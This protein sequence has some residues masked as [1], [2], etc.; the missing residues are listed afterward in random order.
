MVSSDKSSDFAINEEWFQKVFE[1]GRRFKIMNPDK[2]RTTYGKLMYILQDAMVSGVRININLRSEIKC[3]YTFLE[4][5]D[6]VRLLE[7]PLLVPATACI[8]SN[9][10]S[11]I[12]QQ[13]TQKKRSQEKIRNLY[14]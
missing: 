11:E 4:E 5:K 2:M 12:K 14:H 9:K 7:D 8:V 6:A 3:V 1:I 13:Q 10:M